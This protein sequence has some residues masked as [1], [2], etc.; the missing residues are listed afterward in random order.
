MKYIG[1]LP[2]CLNIFLLEVISKV[3]IYIVSAFLYSM[4]NNM[5]NN[6]LRQVRGWFSMLEFLVLL[7]NCLHIEA[8]DG[9]IVFHVPTHPNRGW[10]TTHLKCL[11]E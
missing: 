3:D 9:G 1:E 10:Q 7:W 8:H 6:I 4:A 5:T 11:P 2:G